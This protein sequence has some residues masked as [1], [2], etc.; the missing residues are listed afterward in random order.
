MSLMDKISQDLKLAMKAG[1]KIGWMF[2]EC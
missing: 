2:C 1:E